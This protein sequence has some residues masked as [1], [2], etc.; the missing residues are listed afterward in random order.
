MREQPELEANNVYAI[1]SLKHNHVQVFESQLN[2]RKFL[3]AKHT[4]ECPAGVNSPF[5][6]DQ[7]IAVPSEPCVQEILLEAVGFEY[8]LASKLAVQVKYILFTRVSVPVVLQSW[9]KLV[10]TKCV[11]L[12]FDTKTYIFT[13]KRITSTS[14]L[15]KFAM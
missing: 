5:L 1:P 14:K 12:C 13:I 8:G 11:W 10:G 2:Q 7:N 6:S 4:E 15:T 3:V 9:R